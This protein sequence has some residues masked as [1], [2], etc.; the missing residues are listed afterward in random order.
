[1]SAITQLGAN[2]VNAD[3]AGHTSSEPKTP[4]VAGP[5]WSEIETGIGTEYGGLSHLFGTGLAPVVTDVTKATDATTGRLGGLVSL[6]KPVS[7]HAGPGPGFQPN[8]ATVVAA[9]Q[10]A[11]TPSLTSRLRKTLRI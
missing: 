8:P 3:V 5:Q 2:K 1:M 7:N 10:P 9:E 6:I 4:T 11:S